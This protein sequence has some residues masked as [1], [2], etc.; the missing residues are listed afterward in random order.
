M[1]HSETC[2]LEVVKVHKV[3]VRM[4]VFSYFSRPHGCHALG[5]IPRLSIF[6]VSPRRCRILHQSASLGHQGN[7]LV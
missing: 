7:A 2:Q 3:R 1:R 4:C 5:P 6:L